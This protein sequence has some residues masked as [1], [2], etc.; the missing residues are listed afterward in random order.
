MPNTKPSE[1][2]EIRAFL[3]SLAAR[4]RSLETLR[5]YRRSVTRFAQFAANKGTPLLEAS[6][7]V[8]EDWILSLREAG[9]TEG[10]IFAGISG[11]KAF[12]RWAE[13]RDLIA[14]NPCARIAFMPREK[15]PRNPDLLEARRFVDSIDPRTWSG[16]RDRAVILTLYG[17]GCRVSELG[18]VRLG[19]LH[20]NE[21]R[22]LGKGNKE[23]LCLL[24]AQAMEAINRWIRHH[25]SERLPKSDH[26]F[27]ALSGAPLLGAGIRQM[28]HRRRQESGSLS[29]DTYRSGRVRYRISA[30]AFRHLFATQLLDSGAEIRAIQELL[31]HANIATT[32]RYAHVSTALKARTHAMLPTL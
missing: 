7:T 29:C 31:G 26:L 16:A 3:S 23:R 15:I 20:E 21:M 4:N 14:K 5:A 30:H 9:L 25:R 22:V 12:F 13:Y 28:I 10:S 19:D 24:P 17:S 27:V 1:T 8:I 18:A 2:P 32:Q 11:V 6:P